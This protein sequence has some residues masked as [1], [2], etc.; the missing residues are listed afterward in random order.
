MNLTFIQGFQVMFLLIIVAMMIYPIFMNVLFLKLSE[1]NFYV[2]F[3]SDPFFIMIKNDYLIIF[4]V[5]LLLKLI[6]LHF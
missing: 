6:E 1:L 2:R 4:H 3:L 5:F